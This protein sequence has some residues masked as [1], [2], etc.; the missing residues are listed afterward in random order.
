VDAAARYYT[1]RLG[2]RSLLSVPGEVCFLQSAPG[3]ALALFDA[4][5]FDAD[6]GRPLA[7][8]VVLA[9]IVDTEDEVH[10][11]LD[12]LVAAGGELVMAPQHADWGG[13]HGFALDAAGF[14]W[15]IAVNPGW[16]VAEDG[17]VTLGAV[18]G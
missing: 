8:P 3:Q 9:Q 7:Q 2:W 14:C 13:Y 16:S 11:V 12:E 18:G 1:E 4:A 5:G 6:A 15:D 10:A 17:T